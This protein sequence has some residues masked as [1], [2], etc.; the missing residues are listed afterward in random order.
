MKSSAIRLGALFCG[1]LLAVFGAVTALA[2]PQAANPEH[3]LVILDMSAGVENRLRPNSDQVSITRSVVD[4]IPVV[5]VSIKSGTEGYPGVNIQ[6]PQKVWNLST[7]GHV[8]ARVVNTGAKPLM[9]A[10]RVDNAGEWKDN[11]WNTESITLD[12]GAKGTIT[13]VF[14]YSYGHHLGFPLKSD[15]VVN[16]MLF[17][18]K[19]DSTQSFRIES[20]VAGGTHAEAPPLPPDERRAKPVDGF[21][22]GNHAEFDFKKQVQTSGVE[23]LLVQLDGQ[24]SVRFSFPSGKPDLSASITPYVGRWDLSDYSE[25]KVSVHNMGKAEITPRV[26]LDSNGGSS[27]WISTS[28][29]LPPG[30]SGEILIPFAG[31]TSKTIG[32]SKKVFTDKISAVVDL[33]NSGS[34]ITSDAVRAVSFDAEGEGDRVL[35]LD[36]IQALAPSARLPEWLGKR[37]PVPG[38]W[39]KTLDDNFDGDKIDSSIWSVY[40]EN[41]YDKVSHWS[42]NDV[43]VGGGVARLRYEKKTG[44]HNDDPKRPRT[45]YAAGYLQSYDKWA[46]K[47]GYFEAR[48]KLPKAPGLWPAFWMMPDRGRPGDAGTRMATENGGMEFDIMEHLTRWGPSRYNI[49]MHYDGYGAQH[50]SVGS[51]KIYVQPDKD[52]YITAGLLWLPGSAVFYCNGKEVL[53]WEDTRICNVPCGFLFTIP[54]G[55]WD[56]NPLDDAKL[57]ADFIIDYVR[58][59]QRKDLASPADGKKSQ[60]GGG[61]D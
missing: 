31:L 40:G 2:K 50:K 19:S 7:Y 32:P 47:Y 49:S 20:V 28:K 30:A 12:P 54:S 51:D 18:V 37:P 39:V 43:I 21:L 27:E 26:R 42:K 13:T 14:G 34:Q 38:E 44:F 10:L 15:A 59:W 46:Q 6:A 8:E 35:Y 60:H 33:P 11:P 57:P 48:L 5:A 56:N 58:V 23:S 55:G 41:Y 61:L 1:I 53:R 29:A 45:D 16:M 36:S 3:T 25:V 22:I 52:G 9:L 24:T 4:N 17:T